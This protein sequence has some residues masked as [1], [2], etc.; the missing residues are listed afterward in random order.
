MNN[1]SRYNRRDM[2]K[3]S[4]LAA[5]GCSLV[6]HVSGADASAEVKKGMPALK[7]G[8]AS[9]SL[10]DFPVEK[11]VAVLKQLDVPY[12]AL[13]KKHIPWDGTAE[14]CVAVAHQFTSVGIAVT[15]SGVFTLPND[16]TAVHKAFENAKAVGL[17]TMTC[18]PA[19]NAFPL[20][21]QYVKEYDIRLAI[22]NHGPEDQ[23]Y[24]SPYIAW[25]AVQ[26]YDKRIGLCIDVGH[27]A[28]SGVDPVEAINKCRERLYDVHLKDSNAKVGATHDV[29]VEIGRGKLDITGML[30]ALIKIQ[31][32]YIVGIEFE[33]RGQ[34]Y[35]VVAGLAESVGYVRGLLATAS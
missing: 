20:L 13:H 10:S 18:K 31:Y 25:E 1:D 4:A 14:A 21:D 17:P 3:T 27:A 19:Q 33:K 5:L 30:S 12:V 9:Y 6:T 15:G 8:V 26:S 23:D 32:P 24:P 11:V 34:N 2:L 29:P 35:D 28:R 16:E 7:L 22:H